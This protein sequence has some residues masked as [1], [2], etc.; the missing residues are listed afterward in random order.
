MKDNHEKRKLTLLEKIAIII[1]VTLVILIVLL[2]FN[3]QLMQYFEALRT[4][5]QSS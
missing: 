4:W 2:I 1:I 3:R 5:Y